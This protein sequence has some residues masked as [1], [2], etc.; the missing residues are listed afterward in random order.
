M[1]L[2]RYPLL[3]SHC[4]PI[5]REDPPDLSSAF[6]EAHDHGGHARHGLFYRRSLKDLAALFECDPD[7]VLERRA[8]HSRE[9]L[10]ARYTAGIEELLL[11]DGL[12]P[13]RCLPMEWHA[14][15]VKT[16]RLL[17]LE[18]VA[19]SL[20]TGDS[21]PEFRDRFVHEL[22]TTPVAGFKSIAAYRTGLDIA[23]QGDPEPAYRQWQGQRLALK[24]LN[25]A[26]VRL[27]LELGRP[28]QFHTGFGD[29]DLDLRTANPLCLRPLIEAY[30]KTPIVLL[31]AGYP[32]ARE[33]GFLASVYPN[34]YL[35]F[36]LAVPFLSVAGMQRT[37]SQLLELGPLSKLTW[38]SDASRIPELYYLGALWGRR[39]LGRVLNECIVNGDLDARE[40]EQ[41]ARDILA[42]NARQLYL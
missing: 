8:Q 6:S 9:E 13:D 42:E 34:V 17:R 1:D 27:T 40:A 29:P 11:D 2:S 3:D 25:D 35:D 15:H 24:P 31:H 38:S 26:L 20:Y 32:F 22:E 16:R 41:A 18:Q 28:I 33:A 7:Q 5:W 23:C 10:F 14:G 12:T 37:V 4:H 30:P 36:G 19:E 21:W 39:I